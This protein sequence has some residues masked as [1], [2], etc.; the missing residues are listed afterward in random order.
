MCPPHSKILPPSYEHIYPAPPQQPNQAAANIYELNL[1]R[2][3]ATAAAAPATPAP[4]MQNVLLQQQ[5][6]TTSSAASS[7]QQYQNQNLLSSLAT[8]YRLAQQTSAASNNNNNS[9]P[10][11]PTPAR[12]APKRKSRAQ[13]SSTQNSR[14]ASSKKN[15]KAPPFLLFDA[16][17]ELR[18]SFNQNQRRLGMP[19][20]N[21]CNSYHYGESVKGFH[22]QN[23]G[24]TDGGSFNRKLAT[25]VKLIDGRHA[26]QA[27]SGRIKNE[28][29]QKRAQKITDLI[30]QLGDIMKEGGWKIET[31]SKY[32]TLSS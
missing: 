16:P 25:M 22:P 20:T 10:P 24:S 6:D 2:V 5:S 11:A 8:N 26:P 14:S 23:L 7:T 1:R 29:E 28:R 9:G 19:V 21:D 4:M 32:H 30:D 17:L 3:A 18:T 13:K 15:N 31:K 27:T 12:T